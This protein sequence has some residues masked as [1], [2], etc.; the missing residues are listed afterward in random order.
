MEKMKGL[1]SAES[2]YEWGRRSGN[3]LGSGG[4][5]QA[6]GLVVLGEAEQLGIS[7]RACRAAEMTNPAAASSPCAAKSDE[8]T[9]RRYRRDKEA[10]VMHS[11]CDIRIQ[12]LRCHG[13]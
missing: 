9:D 2:S 8:A 6:K 7:S 1:E 10:I 4:G 12:Y 5:D 13:D 3:G 11:I